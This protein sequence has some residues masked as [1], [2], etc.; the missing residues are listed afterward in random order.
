M[1]ELKDGDACWLHVLGVPILRSK[2]MFASS[3]Q[4]CTEEMHTV[5]EGSVKDILQHVLYDDIRLL[6]VRT[7]KTLHKAVAGDDCQDPYA[8]SNI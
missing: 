6:H 8:P 2:R 3:S 4:D 5:K 7:R 1:W